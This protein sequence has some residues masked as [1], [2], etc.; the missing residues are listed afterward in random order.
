MNNPFQKP[1]ED[2]LL[3]PIIELLEAIDLCVPG[4]ELYSNQ[5]TELER[6][7]KLREETK[8]KRK[9]SKDTLWKVGGNLAGIAMIVLYEHSHVLTSKGI[10]FVGKN[11]F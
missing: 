7:Y 9:V 6:L 4:T 10:G 11:D 8:R 1:E 2:L 5:I 3:R